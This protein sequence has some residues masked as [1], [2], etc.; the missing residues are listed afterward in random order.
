[1]TLFADS[2][3]A[4][5]LKTGYAGPASDFLLTAAQVIPKDQEVKRLLWEAE[6]ARGPGWVS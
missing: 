6:K 1:M 3:G 2:Q 4:A 5:L